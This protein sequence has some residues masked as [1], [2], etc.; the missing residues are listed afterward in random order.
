MNAAGNLVYL[1]GALVAAALLA[2]LLVAL[3]KAEDL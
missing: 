3:L 1:G 2:Y